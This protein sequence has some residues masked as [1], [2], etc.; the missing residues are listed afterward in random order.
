M[1]LDPVGLASFDNLIEWVPI[2]N[3]DLDAVRFGSARGFISDREVVEIELLRLKSDVRLTEPEERIALLLSDEVALVSE[4]VQS[5]ASTPGNDGHELWLYAGLA[6]I[7]QA[8]D[9]LRDPLQAVADVLDYIDRHKHS[10]YSKFYYF[11]PVPLRERPG[12]P[13]RM[14]IDAESWVEQTQL[15]L[16]RPDREEK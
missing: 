6:P 11:D 9:N 4:I 12:G 8:W 1:N 14:R 2:E 15:T 13:T 7:V 5:S 16:Y 3:I 10:E